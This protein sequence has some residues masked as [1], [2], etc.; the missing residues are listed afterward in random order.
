MTGVID[1]SHVAR[2]TT[3]VAVAP[4]IAFEVFTEEIDRWW[5][6]GARFRRGAEGSELR[7]AAADDGRRLIETTGGGA[8][9]AI[10]IGKVLAWEPGARLVFEWRGPDFAPGELTVVEVRFEPAA[11]GT[12]VTLEHRGWEAFGPDHPARHQLDGTGFT[13]ML[14][15]WWADLLT[16][17]R[18]H[19]RRTR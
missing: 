5:R 9:D 18:T 7:F 19:T 3:T 16:A 10:E 1:R 15:L 13:S 17:L 11:G 2:V 12:R 6:R 14:G 4:A 8:A